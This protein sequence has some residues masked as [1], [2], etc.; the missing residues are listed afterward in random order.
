M[1][2]EASTQDIGQ[3]LANVHKEVT[4]ILN[5]LLKP[6]KHNQIEKPEHLTANGSEFRLKARHSPLPRYAKPVTSPKI[7][8]T[9]GS[10]SMAPPSAS[11][12]QCRTAVGSKPLLSEYALSTQSVS[13]SATIVL[14]ETSNPHRGAHKSK[15]ALANNCDIPPESV[16]CRNVG[17][18]DHVSSVDIGALS[19]IASQCAAVSVQDSNVQPRPSFVRAPA[20][21]NTKVDKAMQQARVAR[22]DPGQDLKVSFCSSSFQNRAYSE[23]VEAQPMQKG[24]W[25]SSMRRRGGSAD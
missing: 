9:S 20:S 11:D 18:S 5:L 22:N 8:K 2:V 7:Q 21:F 13:A 12:P 14:L 10:K 3:K 16:G 23:E 4:A 24:R 1:Q 15:S 17:S 6:A 19:D 25:S